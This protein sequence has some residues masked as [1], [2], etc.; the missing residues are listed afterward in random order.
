LLD[1]AAFFAIGGLLL[2]GLS[3]GLGRI[4]T[5]LLARQPKSQA[6]G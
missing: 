1:T 4:R 3:V 2:I 6:E 5:Q